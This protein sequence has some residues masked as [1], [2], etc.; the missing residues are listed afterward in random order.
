MNLQIKNTSDNKSEINLFGEIGES[1]FSESITMQSV[2]D[3][4]KNL[5]SENIIVNISS[6]GGSV[7]HGLAI[8]DILKMHPAKVTAR[9]IGATASAGTLVALGA[10]EVTISENALFLVHNSLTGLYGNA[11]ELRKTANDLDTFDSRIVN[12][13][14]KKTKKAKSDI[15]SLMAE[16]KWIT[17]KEAKDFGFVDSVFTPT[18]ALNKVDIEKLQNKL[19]PKLPENFLNQNDMDTKTILNK[20]EEWGKSI[21]AKVEKEEKSF[22]FNAAIETAKAELETEFKAEIEKV[23]SENVS[24]STNVTELKNSITG[25]DAEIET[26]KQDLAKAR[27]GAV[28]SGSDAGTNPEG[29]NSKD[30]SVFGFMAKKIKT[31][32]F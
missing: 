26:L 28:D 1:W 15:E 9:I 12:I 3:Q 24:L 27:T 14:K 21:L 23:N 16:S 25:K 31:K 11:A 19:L 2:S 22:D 4:I 13:Y 20:I 5:S 6:L 17:P 32:S 30:E 18:A 7:D 29:D 8:H 10:D